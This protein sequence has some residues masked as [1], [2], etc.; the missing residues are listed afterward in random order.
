MNID[1]ISFGAKYLNTVTIKKYDKNTK[2][3]VDLSANFVKLEHDNK[4]DIAAVDKTAEKW[5][6]AKYIRKIATASHWFNSLPID[7]YA[8]TTQKDKFS[9]LKPAKI[10]GFAEMRKDEAF[11]KYDLL[12]HLQVKPD[13]INVNNSD[14][15]YKYVGTSILNSLKKIYKNIFLYSEGNPNVKKFY[16]NNGF[17]EDSMLRRRYLWTSNIFRKIKIYCYNKIHRFGM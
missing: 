13:A 16:Q 6:D 2:G 5:K 7:I 10:L 11:P 17:I 4:F 15:K 8:L 9:K 3:Y 1:S 12:Y 14:A